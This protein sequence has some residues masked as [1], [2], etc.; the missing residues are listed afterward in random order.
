[1]AHLSKLDNLD[2]I[3]LTGGKCGSSTLWSTFVNNNYSSIKVHNT[4]DFKNQ[5]GYDGL[6]DVINKSS[7]NKKLYLIDSY[8]LPI[9][10]K[11]SSFFENIHVHI[12]DYTN[13]SCDELIHIF[14]ETYIGKL[15]EYQSINPIMNHYSV[16]PFQKFDFKKRYVIKECGNLVFI[17]ILF[18]DITNWNK[19][20]STIFHKN[21]VMCNSNLTKNKG[22]QIQLLYTEFKSK[23]K[24]PLSYINNVLKHDKE[25]K[26]FNT[27]EE[28]TRYINKWLKSLY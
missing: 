11:I 5:F 26:I 28:Q 14:N 9:E 20:L 6:I 27:E 16:E 25:F 17:K 8:R 1:M 10:R 24:V 13:K 12:P 4:L 15:E 18:S 23:Y 3:V 7:S 21:I 19:I 22:D 2:V